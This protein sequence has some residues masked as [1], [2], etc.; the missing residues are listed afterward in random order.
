MS[1]FHLVPHPDKP[2]V[3]VTA[4]TVSA[5]RR[6]N[7]LSLDYTVVGDLDRVIWPASAESMR[8]DDLWMHTCFEAFVQ[9]AGQAGYIELNLSPSR[10]WAS[11][12]FDGNRLGMRDATVVPQLAWASPVLAATAD[13]SALGAHDW[14]LGLTAVVEATDGSKSFWALAHGSGAPAPDFH[15]A[16]CFI[17]TLPAPTRP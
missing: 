13:L 14:R 9:L 12:A 4:I 7:L 16:D 6:A 11:Y 17:A 2:S 10:R 15:N 8:T 5:T 3:A 1:D